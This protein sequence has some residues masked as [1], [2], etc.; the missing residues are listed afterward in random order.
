MNTIV[1]LMH[2]R[3]YE[4]TESSVQRTTFSHFPDTYGRERLLKIMRPPWEKQKKYNFTDD[5]P[6]LDKNVSFIMF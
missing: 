4:N 1:R 3:P 2:T 5:S 6:T